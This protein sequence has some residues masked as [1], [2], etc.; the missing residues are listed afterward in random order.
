MPPVG[1]KEDLIA[2]GLRGEMIL[3]KRGCEFVKI[4]DCSLSWIIR[5]QSSLSF[6]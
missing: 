5:E 3:N 4:R 1:T 6:Q 2:H